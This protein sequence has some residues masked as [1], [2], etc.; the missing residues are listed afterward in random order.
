MAGDAIMAS[1]RFGGLGGYPSLK[2]SWQE[3]VRYFVAHALG[4]DPH[5]SPFAAQEEIFR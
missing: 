3:M 2:D 4:W 1:C 5:A